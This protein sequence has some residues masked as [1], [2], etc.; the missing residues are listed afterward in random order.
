[1]SASSSSYINS[2]PLLL[3]YNLTLGWSLAKLSS[4]S[5]D[6]FDSLFLKTTNFTKKGKFCINDCLYQFHLFVKIKFLKAWIKFAKIWNTPLVAWKASIFFLKTAYEFDNFFRVYRIK[7]VVN[8]SN[9]NFKICLKKAQIKFS[10][11]N[12]NLNRA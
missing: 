10:N 7:S 8:H 9:L 12:P 6:S 1:M 5:I 4:S 3:N 2:V 11:A